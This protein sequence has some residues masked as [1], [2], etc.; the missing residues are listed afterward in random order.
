MA[1]KVTKTIKA[2]GGDYATLKALLADDPQ[3]LVA[4]DQ[5][6]E[7]TCDNFEDTTQISTSTSWNLS[8]TCYLHIKAADKHNSGGHITTD[9]YRHTTSTASW[10]VNFQTASACAVTG[11]IIF[12]GI[13]FQNTYNNINSRILIDGTVNADLKVR[14]IDCVFESDGSGYVTDFNDV[15]LFADFINCIA[16]SDD[17]VFYFASA[18]TFNVYHC[19]A[20]GVAY[21]IGNNGATV[22]VKNTYAA[23]TSTAAIQNWAGTMNLTKVACND[24]N[25]SEAGLD[26][27]AYT[28]DNF[29]NVT[30]G[31]EDLHLVVG[32]SS[33]IG[34]GADLSAES[35]PLNVSTDIDGGSRDTSAP[36]IGADE[37]GEDYTPTGGASRGAFFVIGMGFG[38]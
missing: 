19:T 22:N 11:L 3:D 6:W 24:T 1:T 30:A 25:G 16:L 33:L 38:G 4:A 13:Q 23:S 14:F 8:E 20:K 10:N 35:A 5:Y 27:I 15:D 9:A 29:V 36:D 21:A 28:T 26:N 18:A 17:R 34:A 31:S 12:E 7:V 32:A 37:Q 2:S